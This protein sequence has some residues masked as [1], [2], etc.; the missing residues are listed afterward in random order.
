MEKEQ[1]FDTNNLSIFNDFSDGI[2]NKITYAVDDSQR[3]FEGLKR[4]DIFKDGFTRVEKGYTEVN[5]SLQNYKR[6]LNNYGNDLMNFEKKGMDLIDSLN[7]PKTFSLN[8]VLINVNNEQTDLFKKDGK[9]VNEGKETGSVLETEVGE[10]VDKENLKDINNDKV[11]EPSIYDDSS[12]IKTKV[13]DDISSTNNNLEKQYDESSRIHNEILDNIN[14]EQDNKEQEYDDTSL[15]KDKEVL[16]EMNDE[17]VL[18]E[19]QLDD[20]LEKINKITL[21][22]KEN[23]NE[24][25]S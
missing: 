1:S 9:S 12:R 24:V 25:E 14:K 11:E 5:Q 8:D 10:L 23:N 21:E 17:V 2:N 16:D 6:V 18:N 20:R 4:N 7:I 13:L 3:S 15:I 19:Q 22:E